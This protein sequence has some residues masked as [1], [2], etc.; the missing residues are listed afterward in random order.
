MVD[1]VD[2]IFKC[3]QVN[4]TRFQMRLWRI[5]TR[6]DHSLKSTKRLLHSPLILVVLPKL[7]LFLVCFTDDLYPTWRTADQAEEVYE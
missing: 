7:V 1:R 3:A 5:P 6:I 2:W 4:V